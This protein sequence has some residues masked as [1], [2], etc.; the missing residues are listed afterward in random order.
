[1]SQPAQPPPAAGAF[2]SDPLVG[3]KYR[4]LREIG[5]GG[6][7]IVYEVEHIDLRKHFAVKV[8][9]PAYA[10]DPMSLERMRVEAQALGLL[11]S[12][13]IVEVSDW[14]H[15]ADGRPFFVMQLLKGRTGIQELRERGH[16]PPEEAIDLVQ[17]LLE[18]LDVAH[19]AGLVHRDVKLDNLFLNE[20]SGGRRV[21]KILDFGV[22]KVLPGAEGLEPAALRTHEGAIVGTPRFMPPEQAMG[23]PAGPP[24]D[25]YGVGV[26]L[27]EL[28]T[29]RDPFKGVTG[30]APLMRAHVLEDAPAPSTVAPQ[31]IEPVLDDVVMRALAKRPQDRYANAAEFSEALVRALAWS[32][33]VAAPSAPAPQPEERDLREHERPQ[34]EG[35][36]ARGASLGVALL[37]VVASAVLS[38]LVALAFVRG[39]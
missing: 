16:L 22:A 20:E 32:R 5:K 35:P 39:L 11:R 1:M 38:A 25:L 3:S 15:T 13:H 17:Q 8:L 19:R 10:N 9:L 21:L 29:G 27:Y 23:R 18:G 37:L 30:F 14:G 28:L 7:G 33:G 4:A 6:W 12:P 34:A 2:L 24:A 26:V 31:P 36:P